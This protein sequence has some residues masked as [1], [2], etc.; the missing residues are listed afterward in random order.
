M[1]VCVPWKDSWQ[2]LTPLPEVY[3]KHNKHRI[4]DTQIISLDIAGGP[5]LLVEVMSRAL[6]LD[7]SFLCVGIAVE[8]HQPEPLLDR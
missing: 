4:T 3:H 1:E 7:G 8:Q 6:M 5:S 2:Y